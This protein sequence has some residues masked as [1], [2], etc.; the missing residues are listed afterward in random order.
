VYKTQF[1]HFWSCEVRDFST[2]RARNWR[3]NDL[4]D[5]IQWEKYV[6]FFLEFLSTQFSRNKTRSEK[7]K[8]QTSGNVPGEANLRALRSRFQRIKVQTIDLTRRTYGI[9]FRIFRPYHLQKQDWKWKKN[10]IQASF[11]NV[12]TQVFLFLSAQITFL[13]HFLSVSFLENGVDEK[14][15]KTLQVF[16]WVRLESFES[17][18]SEFAS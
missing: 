7:N 9:F 12:E 13:F 11:K 4:I 10:V 6:K 1:W 8:I 15:W 2:P 14:F 3:S 5:E 18:M 16:L 17:L